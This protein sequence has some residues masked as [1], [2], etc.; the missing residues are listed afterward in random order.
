MT[1]PIGIEGIR[2]K[3]PAMIAVSVA[4]Q[5]MQVYE[6]RG[7]IKPEELHSAGGCAGI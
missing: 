5:I 7:R 4:A 3:H 6:S 1:C 2:G